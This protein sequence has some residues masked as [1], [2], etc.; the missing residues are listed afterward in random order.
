MIDVLATLAAPVIGT[1]MT[2]FSVGLTNPMAP[3]TWANLALG[4]RS[5]QLEELFLHSFTPGPSVPSAISF[6]SGMGWTSTQRGTGTTTFPRTQ[7]AV[8]E[9]EEVDMDGVL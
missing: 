6:P 3:I 1:N 7:E 2:L 4:Y 5:S 9:G 8:F